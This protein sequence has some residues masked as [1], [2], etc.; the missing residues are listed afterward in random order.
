M[1]NK[2]KS[3]AKMKIKNNVLL[4]LHV[5]LFIFIEFTVC[6]Q[7]GSYDEK[8]LDSSIVMQLFSPLFM[9]QWFLIEQRK[10]PCTS[11]ACENGFL[12][13]FKQVNQ[14]IRSLLLS[15]IWLK[16]CE[17]LCMF[18]HV[19]IMLYNGYCCSLT[20]TGKR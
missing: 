11:I 5:Y 2:R 3:E 8:I 18:L 12:F 9:S 19:Y 15:L 16:T 6:F 17:V 14:K 10:N 1:I 20:K 4:Y 13:V 7:T